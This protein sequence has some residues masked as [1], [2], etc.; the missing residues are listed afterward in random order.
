M[1]LAEGDAGKAVG[2]AAEV[3]GVE[4]AEERGVPGLG[5]LGGARVD[6]FA[7]AGEN[8]VET[9]LPL[10]HILVGERAGL[11][12]SDR[13]LLLFGHFIVLMGY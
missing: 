3:D 6:D 11:G 4:A 12:S 1:C 9:G 10:F 8:V 5:A 7:G 2:H 13:L